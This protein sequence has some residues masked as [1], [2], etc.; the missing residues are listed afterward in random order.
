LLPFG[1]HVQEFYF[2][3]G[4]EGIGLFVSVQSQ[5][6]GDEE[7][8]P[9]IMRISARPICLGAELWHHCGMLRVPSEAKLTQI[10]AFVQYRSS[11]WKPFDDTTKLKVALE[12]AR[13]AIGAGELLRRI[14]DRSP[15]YTP[16]SFF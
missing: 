3:N 5:E 1:Y 16:P 11:G 15:Q 10:R 4:R 12:V 14:I 7:K 13:P 9:S 8:F 6:T 2:W